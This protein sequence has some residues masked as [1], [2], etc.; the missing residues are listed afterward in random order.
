MNIPPG[1]NAFIWLNYDVQLSRN[2]KHY[3][4]S[5]TIFPYD[6]VDELEIR[7]DIE[8]N[9]DIDSANTKIYL[10]SDGR[11]NNQRRDGQ[12]DLTK[13]KDSHYSYKLSKKN[14]KKEDFKDN[15][16]IEYDLVRKDADTCGDIIVRNG[17][18]VHYIAPEGF[19]SIPKNVI[20][21]ID[22]SGSMGQIRMEMAKKALLTILRIVSNHFCD[23]H[24]WTL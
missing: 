16:M 5:T 12:F 18:F 7:V 22:T 19:D 17:Y 9:Q 24:P 23:N 11:P 14:V 2:R 10:E 13:V 15:L 1:E 8:E 21:T 3:D 4:F 6:A 20:L